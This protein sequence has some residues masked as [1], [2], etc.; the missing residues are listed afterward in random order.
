MELTLRGYG[1][2]VKVLREQ[3]GEKRGRIVKQVYRR[4]SSEPHADHQKEYLQASGSRYVSPL[5]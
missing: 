4:C 3:V 2:R 1:I 5:R